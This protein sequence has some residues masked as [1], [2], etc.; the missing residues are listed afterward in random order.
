MKINGKDLTDLKKARKLLEKES[1]AVR[2][3]KQYHRDTSKGDSEK[4]HGI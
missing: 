2:L 3:A 1:L 4:C